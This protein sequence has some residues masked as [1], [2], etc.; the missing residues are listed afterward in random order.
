MITPASMFFRNLFIISY[1][2]LLIQAYFDEEDLLDIICRAIWPH[3]DEH[4][5]SSLLSGRFVFV[6]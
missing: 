4:F 5:L 3:I 2:P 6:Q 1:H